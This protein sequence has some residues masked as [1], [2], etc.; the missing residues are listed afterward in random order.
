MAVG[1]AWGVVP[2]VA[3]GV[4]LGMRPRRAEDESTE[5]TSLG[6]EAEAAA[7]MRLEAG[8][9]TEMRG[10]LEVD[11]KEEEEEEVAV[12]VAV[13]EEEEEVVAVVVVVV[14]VAVAVG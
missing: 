5:R 11:A 12:V 8:E 3:G 9:A 2:V 6:E 14:V 13:V 4:S 1:V 7:E 10:R